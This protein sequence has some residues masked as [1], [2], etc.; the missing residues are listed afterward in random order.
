M[1]E[2][3]D[4]SGRDEPWLKDLFS[5]SQPALVALASLPNGMGEALVTMQYSARQAHFQAHWPRAVQRVIERRGGIE[6]GR[7]PGGQPVGAL[8][9]DDGADGIHVLDIAVLPAWRCQGIGTRCLQDLMAV[10]ARRHLPV[11]LQ[12]APDNPARRLYERL[13]FVAAGADDGPSLPMICRPPSPRVLHHAA[14]QGGPGP[15]RE[16]TR[17]SRPQPTE[18]CHEQ[19]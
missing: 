3:R 2:L 1:L 11:T 5:V 6:P 9:A 18:T 4:A 14:M 16:S 13:G 12:V 8:W 7:A 15:E 17:E 10:A 19:A